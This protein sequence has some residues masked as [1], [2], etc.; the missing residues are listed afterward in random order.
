MLATNKSTIHIQ[1]I[2]I[3][4][5]VMTGVLSVPFSPCPQIFH[6]EYDGQQWHGVAKVY[7]TVYNGFQTNKITM[8]IVLFINGQIVDSRKFGSLDLYHTLTEAYRNMA[9]RQP[10]MY[11]I[12]FP[13]QT[14]TPSVLEITVN[15]V[16]ICNNGYLITNGYEIHAK[17]QLQ[18][19]FHLPAIDTEPEIVLPLN[20]AL[21]HEDDDNRTKFKP[22]LMDT[23]DQLSAQLGCGEYDKRFRLTHLISG[24]VRITRGTWPWL[25]AIFLK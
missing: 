3:A 1:C 12:N 5:Q 6:Y 24:G 4:F 23:T 11:R 2:F 15:N 21:A 25:V 14:I 22:L 9:M 19:S 7:S 10:I 17:I 13:M 16:K 8:V 18:H 20:P